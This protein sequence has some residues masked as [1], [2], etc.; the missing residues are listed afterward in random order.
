LQG[1]KDAV[2]CNKKQRTALRPLSLEQYFTYFTLG[3][4]YH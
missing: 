2:V 4:G 3:F 1:H